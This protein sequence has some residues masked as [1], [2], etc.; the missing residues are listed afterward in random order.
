MFTQRNPFQN[1]KYQ[2]P[3]FYTYGQVEPKIYMEVQGT[4]DS[5]NNLV[6]ELTFPDF[7]SYNKASH[8]NSV[9]LT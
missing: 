6:K 4:L 1:P 2:P 7:K 8:Q 5:Q 3:L 9:A